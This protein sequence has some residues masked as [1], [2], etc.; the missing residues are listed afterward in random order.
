MYEGKNRR[1]SA[2]ALKT[3]DVMVFDIADVGVR[4]YTYATTMAYAM[5]ECAK[6]HVPFYVLDRPNP[7]TGIHVEGPMLDAANT[8]FIG[9]FPG[10]PVRHGMTMG[11]LARMFN[12]ERHIGADLH[13]IA[14]EG[15]SRT[16]WFDQ[17]GLPWV[18]PSPNIRSLNAALLYPG[19]GMIEYS[20]NWSVGRGT[21]A[22]FEMVGGEF[23]DGPKLAAYLDSRAIPGV[24]VYP[25]QFQP[26]TSKL[27]G[28]LVNGVRFVVTDRDVFDSTRLGTEVATALQK[29]YPGKIDFTLSKA[30]IGSNAFVQGLAAGKD[31]F[32]L[33]KGEPLERFNEMRQRYLLYR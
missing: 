6:A 27:S 7:I 15:W 14:M 5:E 32:E 10:G 30:L 9:Y 25:V 26:T 20:L 13:V 29:L 3:V 12:E 21:D 22:P 17:T 18:D 2:E 1:P 24:R 4:F 16:E 28:K 33:M 11:E 23:V 31:P 8:A 19:L